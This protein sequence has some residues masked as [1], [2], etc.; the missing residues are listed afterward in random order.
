MYN[1]NECLISKSSNSQAAPQ[2]AGK[3]IRKKEV[4]TDKELTVEE[5]KDA[6][7]DAEKHEEN[8]ETD[9]DEAD[10]EKTGQDTS[11]QTEGTGRCYCHIWTEKQNQVH[12]NHSVCFGENS[13]FP[14][15]FYLQIHTFCLL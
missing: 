3:R 4:Q 11:R 14:K 12:A 9:A 8:G 6:A 1:N 2:D 10:G 7:K 5:A 15:K 13:F